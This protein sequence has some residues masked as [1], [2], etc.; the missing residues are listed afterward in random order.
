MALNFVD[1]LGYTVQ[2]DILAVQDFKTTWGR[3]EKI[4]AG[5]NQVPQHFDPVFNVKPVE[6]QRKDLALPELYISK[7][8]KTSGSAS[9]LLKKLI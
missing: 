6:E 8:S 7:P 2:R 3:S 1:G 9:A 4:C 5:G